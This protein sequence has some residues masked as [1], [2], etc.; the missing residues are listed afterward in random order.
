MKRRYTSQNMREP[1]IC[2]VHGSVVPRVVRRGHLL[3]RHC[4]NCYRVRHEKA[5]RAWYLANREK[6]AAARRFVRR[7]FKYRTMQAYGGKCACCGIRD[8]EFLTIDHVKGDGAN[9]R[10]AI[11]GGKRSSGCGL[12]FYAWLEKKGY[13]EGFRVLC[14]NCNIATHQNGVCPHD[15]G[16]RLVNE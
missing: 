11:F 2:K 9:H 16:L 1:I 10:K 6:L 3:H 8:L 14:Y 4:P 13:P 15:F 12:A 7:D 5:S